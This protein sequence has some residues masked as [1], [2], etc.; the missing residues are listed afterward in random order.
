MNIFQVC[1]E[2]TPVSFSGRAKGSSNQ[3]QSDLKQ[4]E[5]RSLAALL[6]VKIGLTRIHWNHRR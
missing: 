1:S 2:A 4:K 6:T 5:Q 3:E